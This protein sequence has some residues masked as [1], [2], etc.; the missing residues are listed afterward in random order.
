M[1]FIETLIFIYI[2]LSP[3][4][5]SGSLKFLHYFLFFST[6]ILI[7]FVIFKEKISKS[8][9]IPLIFFSIFVIFSI[10]TVLPL[11]DIFIKF[12]SPELYRII[13]TFNFD[14]NYSL[15]MSPLWTLRNLS[16]FITA[17]SIFFTSYLIFKHHKEKTF[18]FSRLLFFSIF[19]FSLYS[20]ILK[21]SN[22]KKYP[23]PPFKP[24]EWNFGLFP[25]ANIFGSFA[26]FGVPLGFFLFLYKLK[27]K[28]STPGSAIFYLFGSAFLIFCIL[29]A[30][31]LGPILALILSG[32]IYFGFRKPPAGII[33]FLI[34]LI[35]FYLTFPMFPEDA[36]RSMENRLDF[37]KLGFHIF[38]KYPLFGTGLGTVPVSSGIYQNALY[39]II[40]DKI[41]NDYIEI[42]STSGIISIFLFL[43][44][45]IVLWKNLIFFKEK[46]ILRCG[47]MVSI[48]SVLIHSLVDFPLQNFTVMAYFSFSLGFLFINH[49]VQEEKSNF[50]KNILLIFLILGISIQFLFVLGLI[51]VKY[52]GYSIF[53]PEESFE[54]VRGNP[55]LGLKFLKF[56]PFYAPIWGERARALEREDKLKDAIN[57]LENA[58][59]LEPI[60]P[61]LYPLAAKLYFIQGND[62]KY[63]ES[64]SFALGLSKSFSLKPF[65][66]NREELEKV[67]QRSL[68]ISYKFY[69]KDSS[70][71][72]IRGYNI[73]LN[74]NSRMAKD[75]IEEG[76]KKFPDK[77]EILYLLASEYFKENNLEKAEELN[78][79]SYNIEKNLLN[80]LLFAN[81]Y[82]KRGNY[83]E[84]KKFLYEGVNLIKPDSYTLN[85]FV[86]GAFLMKEKNVQDAI[87][88]LKTG[89]FVKPYPLISFYIGFFEEE[90]KN[91]ISAE[92]WYKKTIQIDDKFEIGYQGLYRIYKIQNDIKSLEEL[93][94]QA[95]LKFPESKWYEEK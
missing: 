30:Q 34:F 94:S 42:L 83:E 87:E 66:L 12:L 92:D 26:M 25:N 89:F 47:I 80:T 28:N 86:H 43:C 62:Q 51:N 82:F 5:L 22:L 2:L 39:E 31:S 79:K 15:S 81:I 95:K 1:N 46:Y 71:F 21:I 93:R 52:K 4:L 60:N 44:I 67:V 8:F 61:K 9:K 6:S 50:F 75:V 68:E 56:H 72:F 73:L 11:P 76:A 36:K 74:S 78:L 53:Y 41:H 88:F 29:Y 27:Q 3:L 55:E 19:S 69:G 57:S 48:I 24:N 10:F 20:L 49:K 45:G 33:L 17:V 84:G 14:R 32:I 23:F 37:F 54:F 18:K 38:L 59:L 35:L 63:L 13:S 40:V 77:P 70:I 58:I 65:P 91:F 90:R 7:F 85:Y 16:F 64:L